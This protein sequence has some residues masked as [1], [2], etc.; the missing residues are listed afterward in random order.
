MRHRRR[1]THE[2][3]SPALA[4]D[5]PSADERRRVHDW[6][7]VPAWLDGAEVV[8]VF[9]NPGDAPSARPPAANRVR[10]TDSE[11]D[12]DAGGVVAG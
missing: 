5:M 8:A 3:R 9:R 7:L 1:F 12:P 4:V 2:R 6:H 10:D 11:R